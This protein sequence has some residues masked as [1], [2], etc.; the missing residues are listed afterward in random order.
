MKGVTESW[1]AE[2]GLVLQP[3]GSYRR[4]NMLDK[5]L[6]QSMPNTGL[7]EAIP[8]TLYGS[9]EHIGAQEGKSVK[10]TENKKIRN[11]VKV[12][13]DGEE[14]DSRLEA[15]TGGLFKQY[16]IK[17]ERQ[18]CYILQEKFRYGTELIRPITLTVDFILPDYNLIVDPKG[19]AND[20]APLKY[21]MLKKHLFDKGIF[22]EI[23][24]PRNHKECAELINKLIKK[25]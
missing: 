1:L 10:S 3:D 20:R 23:V 2:K 21:K 17:F 13:I 4:P 25:V 11:A 5:A 18:V 24:M 19:F 22:M 16:G 8:A 7:F 12:T 9:K 15:H 6:K 14:Y